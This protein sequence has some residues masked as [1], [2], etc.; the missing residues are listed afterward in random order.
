MTG[1]VLHQATDTCPTCKGTGVLSEPVEERFGG[2]ID[3]PATAARLWL[4]RVS[5]CS[6]LD[7]AA[8]KSG[9]L[10]SER[11]KIR[12]REAVREMPDG[13]LVE[14]IGRLRRLIV[15]SGEDG[16]D[17]LDGL[18]R[19]RH[20]MATKELAWRNRAGDKGANRVHADIAW[21]ERV[22][23]IR[24]SVDLALLIAYENAEAKPTSG[25][26]WKCC[27]P[28]HDDRSPSLDI[29]VRKGVW[30]CRGCNVGGDA[31]T[32]VELRY[33]LDFAGAVRYL[34]NRL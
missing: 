18:T 3:G 24:A 30:I 31:F 15:M 23:K 1:G 5:G 17:F 19:E 6:G 27:C 4:V 34:E 12:E 8:E 10:F 29:D 20:E 16:L 33:G 14:H 7:P 32:Y 22:D 13:L 28:F 26:K 25:G 11:F 9:Y 21:R 2:Y